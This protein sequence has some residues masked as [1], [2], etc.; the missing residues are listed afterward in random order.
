MIRTIFVLFA[1]II[2]ISFAAIFIRFCDDVP[3]IM[4]ATYRLSVASLVLGSFYIFKGNRNTF[5]NIRRRDLLLCIA[6]GIFLALHFITWISSLKYTSVASSVVL[7]TTNPIFV[8]VFSFLILKEKQNLELVVGIILCFVGS[9]LIAVGDSGLT[10]LTVADKNSLIGDVLAL[11]GAVMASGYLI[12]GS[13]A[14]ET[15]DIMAY[16]T[17]V[18]SVSAVF[19]LATSLVLGISFT[20]YKESSYIFMILLAIV[21]QL[22]GHTSINWALKHLKTSMVAI[23]ILGEPIGATIL[24]YVFFH[25]TVKTIQFIG[26]VFVFAAIIVASRKGRR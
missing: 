15:V 1:G 19:L 4:I 14:R 3:S 20:G 10:G 5:G 9:V 11:V 16:V 25:E 7:V 18:F 22:I 21:P 17:V 23:T 13:K 12:I 24:A 2:S 6:G 8:G 26:M